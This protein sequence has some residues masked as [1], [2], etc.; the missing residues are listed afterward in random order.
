VP[1]CDAF[2]SVVEGLRRC[3]GSKDA[4]KDCADCPE[5]IVL[6]AGEFLANFLWDL[7]ETRLEDRMPRDRSTGCTLPIPLPW[8]STK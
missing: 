6:P 2:E 7:L 4:F 1:A 3:F 5:M 8:E